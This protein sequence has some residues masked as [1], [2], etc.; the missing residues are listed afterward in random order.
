MANPRNHPTRELV[1]MMKSPIPPL[2]IKS[3]LSSVGIRL[4][5]APFLLGLPLAF[6]LPVAGAGI[7]L[8][9]WGWLGFSQGGSFHAPA[10]SF[11]APIQS[12]TD[13]YDMIPYFAFIMIIMAVF[14]LPYA[15]KGHKG[16][17]GGG[18]RR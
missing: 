16:M 17:R 11:F 15:Y 12:S 4:W 18:R 7:L 13:Y 14:A 6:W 10:W 3:K 2:D 9:I 8:G 5:F 1:V